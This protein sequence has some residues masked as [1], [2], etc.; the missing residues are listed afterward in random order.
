MRQ[1]AAVMILVVLFVMLVGSNFQRSD[2][3]HLAQ[4]G[5]LAVNRFRGAMPPMERLAGPMTALKRT[6]PTRLEDRVRSRLESDRKLEGLAIQVACEGGT[7]TL[8]G[9]VPDEDAHR[10][11]VELTQT[12]S[13]IEHVIDELVIADDAERNNPDMMN[14]SSQTP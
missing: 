5:R 4:I 10:R 2:G 9:F 6:I 8:R 7:V 11:A 1:L 13:G 12:T 3:E 14:G